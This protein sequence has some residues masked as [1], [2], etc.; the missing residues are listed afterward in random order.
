ML[1]HGELNQLDELRIVARGCPMESEEKESLLAL[2]CYTAVSLEMIRVEYK[3]RS[4]M[5]TQERMREI[6]DLIRCML[7]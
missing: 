2:P 1:N 3:T 6:P 7:N 4:D 5:A